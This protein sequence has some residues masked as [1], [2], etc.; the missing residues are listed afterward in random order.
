MLDS[1]PADLEARYAG[2]TFDLGE[3]PLVISREQALRSAAK[4][5]DAVAHVA[6]MYRHL[7]GKGIPFE[8]EV[9]VDETATP[10]THAEHYYVAAELA[11]LGVRWVSLGPR[12]VGRFEKGVDSIGDLKALAADLAGQALVA[13]ALGP[14]KL[15]LHSGSDKF[16]IYPLMV[17]AAHGQ[18]HLKTAGTSYLEALRV[19]ADRDLGFF[20]EV[21]ALA[22]E[23]YPADRASYHVSA[24]VERVPRPEAL[25]DADL[26]ALLDG[27]ASFDAR[28]VLHVT[29]GSVL[30]RWGQRLKALLS[31][32]EDAYATVLEQHFTRHLAPFSVAATSSLS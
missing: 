28:Q 15:S 27:A 8:L 14:Y 9:S 10:T 12:F 2:R 1:S 7:A 25:S 3:R 6:R 19:V 4:Y 5:G 23:R 24:Q 32:N 13:R 29:F 11:R 31:E 18:M 22:H 21:L 20:R 16:S 17:E 26:P 30:A